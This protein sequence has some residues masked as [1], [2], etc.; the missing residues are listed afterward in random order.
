MATSVKLGILFNLHTLHAISVMFSFVDRGEYNL[1]QYQEIK[2]V[3]ISIFILF[4]Q[5]G[6]NISYIF[7]V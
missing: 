4:S 1:S 5:S 7:K 3:S 6:N 2:T